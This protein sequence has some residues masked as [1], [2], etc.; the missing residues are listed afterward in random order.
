MTSHESWEPLHSKFLSLQVNVTR[1]QFLEPQ[2]QTKLQNLLQATSINLS[3]QRTQLSKPVTGKD[4]ISFSKQIESVANQVRDLSVAARL[5]TL[6]S[7]TRRVL[8]SH[9]RPLETKKVKNCLNK[10]I[11]ITQH[12]KA[13][14]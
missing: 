9:I 3:S 13:S 4:L 8:D 5:E 11:F 6:A 7:R 2:L 14:L 1:L 12:I 10:I